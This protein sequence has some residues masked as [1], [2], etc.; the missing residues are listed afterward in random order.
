MVKKTLFFLFSLHHFAVFSQSDSLKNNINEFNQDAVENLILSTQNDNGFELNTAFEHLEHFAKHKINLNKASREDLTALQLLSPMQVEDF[1][2]YHQKLG[3]LIAVQE[4]QAIPSFD[5]ATI[6]KILPFVKVSGT[7]DDYQVGLKDMVQ[8]AD[9][10]LFVRSTTFVEKSSGFQNG[11]YL[12]NNFQ[13]YIRFKRAFG[14]KFSMGFT[15]EKDRGEPY[16]YEKKIVGADFMSAHLAYKGRRFQVIFGDFMANFGQGLVLFQDFAPGKS[17]FITDLKR[18]HRVIRPY[19]SVAE[20]NFLRGAAMTYQ[21]NKNIDLTA[22]AS[23]RKRDATVDLDTTQAFDEIFVSL[24]NS[25]LHRTEAEIANKNA[26]QNLTFGSSVKYKT[27]NKQ[28]GIN[29]L[30]NK[31]D[32][33]FERSLK[34]YNQFAFRG[35]PLLNASVDYAYVYRNFNFFGETAISDNGGKG[36][37]NGLLIGMDKHL[38][39]SILHRY[40]QANYQSLLA[41]PIAEALGATNE[42]GLYAGVSIL[43]TQKWKI[44]SY[45]DF[46]KNN[47]LRFQIN[48]PSNGYEFYNRITFTLKRKLDVYLQY[49]VKSKERNSSES[50]LL[51]SPLAFE[52]RHQLRL[53]LQYQISPEI[54]WESRVE[55][56]QYEKESTNSKG[57]LLYQDLKFKPKGIPFSFTARYCL[58]ETDDYNSRIYAFENSLMYLYSIPAL[59]GK[60]SRFYFNLRYTPLKNLMIETRFAQNFLSNTDSVGTGNETVLGNT[61]TEIGVQARYNF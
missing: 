60:G 61:K 41:N 17:P 39:M 2:Q 11:K 18:Q 24:L 43:P 42:N 22:F 4:L 59:Y 40:Y 19:T 8:D 10:Q 35:Q 54:E 30:Y 32:K 57:Y 3:D 50:T 9:N 15:L 38:N 47:W 58:F 53:N 21:I 46:W 16:R 37:V 1:F 28:L 14:T 12:G 48:A 49:R 13:H 26:I 29:L 44:E 6:K 52:K 23:Y 51:I 36:T 34:P 56:A 25:G 45:L 5:M 33:P 27:N 7:V 20:S 31:F 55:Y